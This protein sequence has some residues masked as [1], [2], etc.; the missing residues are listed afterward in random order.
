MAAPVAAVAVAAIAVINTASA[1]SHKKPISS[2]DSLPGS[3]A[4]RNRLK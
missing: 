1:L 3:L 4:K 2:N